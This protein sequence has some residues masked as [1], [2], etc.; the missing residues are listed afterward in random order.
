M[1]YTPKFCCNCGEKIE[2]IDWKLWTS[3][4]FCDVCAI[5]KQGYELLPRAIVGF[6]LLFGIFGIG[7]YLYEKQPASKSLQNVAVSPGLKRELVGGSKG[8]PAQ[9][10]V[11]NL[12][13][14]KN[15][16]QAAEPPAVVSRDPK[17]SKEQPRIRRTASD[18]AVFFCGAMTKKGKPCSR[19]VKS[20]N[21]RCWQHAGQPLAAP[22]PKMTDAF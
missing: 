16:A 19:R 13:V 18:E 5:E 11:R 3:R 12:E 8:Q 20:S 14:G 10:D 2:R 9:R 6:A 22:V 21:E 15:E 17:A 1:F 4:R 7:S